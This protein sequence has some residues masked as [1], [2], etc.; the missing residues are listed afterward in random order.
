ME[1]LRGLGYQFAYGTVYNS[2]RY[3]VDMGMIRELKL[4]NAVSRYDARLEDHIHIIC[5]DCGKIDEAAASLPA[6]W[7]QS[8]ERSSGYH[9]EQSEVVLHGR[10]PACQQTAQGQLRLQ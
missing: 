9:I 3:L 4:G 7:L 5:D 1:R 8:I 10:C 2:L 6:E